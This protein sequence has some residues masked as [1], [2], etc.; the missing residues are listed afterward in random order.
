LGPIKNR[1]NISQN[2]FKERRSLPDV[3]HLL[4]RFGA[5]I[6]TPMACPT[7]VRQRETSLK[8]IVS[9]DGEDATWVVK[10][11]L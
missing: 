4:L 5:V 9:K 11:D 10:P 3:V 8:Y 1:Q 6:V 2:N 7:S